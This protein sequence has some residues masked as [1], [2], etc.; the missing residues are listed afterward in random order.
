[1]QPAGDTAPDPFDCYLSSPAV[2]NGTVYF[3]SGDGNVYALDAASGALRWKVQ[4]GNVVHASPAIADGTGFIGSWDTYFYALD[5]KSGEKKWALP[6]EGSWVVASAA[7]RGDKVDVTTSD[8][9]LLLVDATSGAVENKIGFDHWY[10][11]SSPAIAGGTPYVGS[12]QG[13]VTAIDLATFKVAWNFETQTMKERGREYTKADGSPN[14]DAIYGTD[15]YDDI[16]V[17]VKRTMSMGAVIGSPVI[18]R[19]G[20]YVGSAD[21]NLYA[22]M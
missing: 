7:V 6:T 14:A 2:W 21:G 8:S 9:S 12:T 4:T 22:L 1:V 13:K 16:V 5:E 18:A 17:G 15:F 11:F 3:G 10:V 20:V 19:N